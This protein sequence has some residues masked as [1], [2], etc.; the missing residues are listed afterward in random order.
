MKKIFTN[1]SLF[2]VHIILL[3]SFIGLQFYT[4]E[5][6]FSNNMTF[7]LILCIDIIYSVL[8]YHL[9]KYTCGKFDKLKKLMT[10]LSSCFSL[11]PISIAFN[12]GVGFDYIA[13]YLFFLNNI[14]Y[15]WVLYYVDTRKA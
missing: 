1:I 8:F 3:F 5:R 4:W 15:I 13:L 7:L 12:Q 2:L 11:F 9:Y 14:T 6:I 10:I